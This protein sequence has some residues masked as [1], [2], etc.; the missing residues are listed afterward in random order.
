MEVF[1]KNFSLSK[2]NNNIL[3]NLDKFKNNISNLKEIREET[4]VV[5]DTNMAEYFLLNYY[6]DELEFWSEQLM[7][8]IEEEESKYME[9]E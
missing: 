3:M 6:I 2:E 4:K 7:E 9:F 1:L 5:E 8:V